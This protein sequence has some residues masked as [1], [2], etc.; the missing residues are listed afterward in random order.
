MIRILFL[1][2]ISVSFQLHANSVIENLKH[3]NPGAIVKNYTD[4]PKEASL[5]PGEGQDTLK[6]AGLKEINRNQKANHLY[7]HLQ[8]RSKFKL[9]PESHEM[10]MAEKI[11]EQAESSKN[12]G[13]Y[14]VK[15]ACKRTF[16]KKHC[17]ESLQ[18]SRETCK[19]TRTVEIKSFQQRVSRHISSRFQISKAF[20]LDQC[21][22]TDRYCKYRDILKISDHCVKLEAKAYI[23]GRELQIASQPSCQNPEIIVAGLP[24]KR[25]YTITMTVTEYDALDRFMTKNCDLELKNKLCFLEESLCVTPHK[26]KNINGINITR[27]CWDMIEHYQC[28]QISASNCGSLM[29]EGCSQ[30]GSVC[31][32]KKDNLCKRYDQTFSCMSE[33]C[34]KEQEICFEKRK[35]ADGQCDKSHIDESHDMGEGISRLGALAGVAGD[36]AANQVGSG[37]PAI[38]TG[39]NHRCRMLVAGLGNCCGG[40]ARFLNCRDEEKQLAKAI[41]EKRAFYVGKYCAEKDIVCLKH[42]ESWCVFPSKLASIIQIE[43][44]YQQLGINFGAAWGETNAA[45]CRGITPE[46]IERINF[47]T[48]D[49]SPIEKE[50]VARMNP[51]K[52]GQI[53]RANQSHIERLNREG[54]AYD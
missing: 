23:K 20:K 22:K 45:D 1:G 27:S 14:K 21:P 4:N 28:G 10:Q 47:S 6:A 16:T 42:K 31:Q 44:R 40:H 38:F 33:D 52:H 30:I 35:C 19:K 26:T 39:N 37:M 11:Q 41:E 49:L 3:F 43:G 51:P 24:L 15:G 34:E 50:M 53:S 36:V 7:Q 48:L 8:T 18:Y 2:F 12:G 54:R 5:K 29:Q 32:S 13:C 17:Q 9:N 46:E 25:H